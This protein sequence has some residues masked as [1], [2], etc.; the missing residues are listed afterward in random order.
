MV[1]VRSFLTISPTNGWRT[2]QL[3]VTNTFLDG[4]PQEVLQF[5]T[6][7]WVLS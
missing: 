3:G 2:E 1:T 5:H 6:L 4:D 7:K